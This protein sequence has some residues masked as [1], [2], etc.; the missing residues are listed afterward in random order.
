GSVLAADEAPWHVIAGGG[1]VS[2]VGGTT[3]GGTIGQA[4]VGRSP[5]NSYGLCSG[6]WCGA[7]QP[8]SASFTAVPGSGVAP[9]EV[10][11]NNTSTGDYTSS[12]WDFG[13]GESSTLENPTHTYTEAG[14]YTVSLTV[15]GP[16]GSDTDTVHI[17]V[18]A[19]GNDLYLPLVQRD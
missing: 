11:F 8:V 10:T 1:G 5:P 17:L 13:D 14:T 4:I 19:P 16:G 2:T 15:A 3:L 7:F 12:A 18:E 6:F 9:L